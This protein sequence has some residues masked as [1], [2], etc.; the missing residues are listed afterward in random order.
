MLNLDTTINLDF[1][2]FLHWWGGELS[3]LVPESVRQI[4]NDDQGRLIVRLI[5]DRLELSFQVDGETERIAEFQN[6]VDGMADLAAAL[7]KDSRFD[8]ADCVL[9]LNDR[10]ALAKELVFPIA[11]AEN[12]QQ[13]VAYELDRYTPFTPEQ[14]YLAVTILEKNKASGQI[15]C[16]LILAPKEKLDMLCEELYAAGL[17]PIQVDYEA[18]ENDAEAGAEPYNLLPERFRQQP[19]LL[20]RL[21]HG[22]L[23]GAVV[24][25]LIAALA[26]PVVWQSQAVDEL[27]SEIKEIER[28]AQKVDRLQGEMD[29]LISQTKQLIDKKRNSPSLLELLNVLSALIKDDTWLT[30]FRYSE[31]RLQ[32]QGQSPSASTLIALL[33]ESKLFANARF[34]S[35]VTQDRRSGVE[36]FQITVDVKPGRL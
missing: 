20:P 12:L 36:R 1:K 17:R 27:R 21:V 26:L 14:A 2:K 9:R 16:V 24:L 22:G 33:E 19:A 32:F 29:A 10:Y 15:K 28:E 30:H 13:V 5:E 11:V 8:K 6:N 7:K 3:F 25:L 34:V 18:V 23:L 31:G 35:P 4:V